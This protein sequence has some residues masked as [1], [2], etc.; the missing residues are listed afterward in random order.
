MGWVVVAV[1]RTSGARYFRAVS[2]SWLVHA[3]TCARAMATAG[4]SVGVDVEILLY[5]VGGTPVLLI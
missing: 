1:T 2:K 3:S 5:G 4:A